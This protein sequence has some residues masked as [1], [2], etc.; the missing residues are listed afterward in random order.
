MSDVGWGI[1]GQ[2]S[3]VGQLRC[4]EP[5]GSVPEVPVAPSVGQWGKQRVQDESH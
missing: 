4:P 5:R 1:G 2:Y 3:V